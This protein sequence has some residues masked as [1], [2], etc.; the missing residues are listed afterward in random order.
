MNYLMLDKDDITNVCGV[1]S[2]KDV[3]KEITKNQLTSI[4]D[5]PFKNLFRGK[6]IL[7]E[8]DVSKEL[9]IPFRTGVKGTY[10]VTS[11]G[12]FYVVY[13]K[14]KKKRYL[15]PYLKDGDFVVR[16]YDKVYLCKNLIAKLFISEYKSGDVVLL[17]DNR[18]NNL[19]V[20]NLVV[21]PK[22]IYAMKTGPLSRSQA[23]GLFENN[24]IVKRWSSAR[25]CAKDM[26]CSCQTIMDYCN[27]KVKK[28]MFDVRWI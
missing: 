19:K 8:D 1:I 2:R 27:G 3:L 12:K 21:I 23:V 11:H 16:I 4:L 15:K 6:Y 14:S 26:Y 10:F 25:K 7:V 13:N 24:K 9:V 22:E 20:D 18:K 28:P 5:W 17:K